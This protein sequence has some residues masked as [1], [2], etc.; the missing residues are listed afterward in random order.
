MK[1]MRE[2]HYCLGV[3]IDHE[4]SKL[5][6]SQKR[7]VLKKLREFDLN[8]ANTVV[9]LWDCNVQLRKKDRISEPICTKP[10]EILEVY[11]FGNKKP[12]SITAT[13]VDVNLKTQIAEYTTVRASVVYLTSPERF[14]YHQSYGNEKI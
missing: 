5:F 13:I 10:Y 7:F 4:K 3:T 14:K 8:E 11:T 6:L 1:D 9:T 12:K 2:S